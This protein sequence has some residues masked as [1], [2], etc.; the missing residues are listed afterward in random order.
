MH[1]LTDSQRSPRI[2]IVRAF[3]PDI[4]G[5]YTAK[6]AY[7]LF[8]KSFCN[9]LCIFL[10]VFDIGFALCH[11]F[12]GKGSS[13]T[14]LD[15]IGYAIELGSLAA[16]PHS[17]QGHFL[18]IGS[19]KFQVFRNDGVATSGSGKTCCFGKGAEFNGT[20]SA[21]SIAKMLLGRVSSVMKHH[22]QNHRV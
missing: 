3:K 15:D 12:Y 17:I 7:I 18:T 21:P 20:L 4:W 6:V 11:T 2:P 9:N 19:S 8:L 1:S 14:F 16:V 10:I 13:S 22:K 5:I